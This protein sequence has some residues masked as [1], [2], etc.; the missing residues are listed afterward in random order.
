M[1]EALNHF[2]PLDYVIFL[3]YLAITVIVGLRFTKQQKDIKTYLLAGKT[4]GAAVV[5]ISVLAAFFSGISYL[6]YPSEIYSNGIGFFV[7]GLS[8]FIATPITTII[9]LP[10]FCRSGFLTAYQYLLASPPPCWTH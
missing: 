3:A 6:A 10:F 5:G 2:R 9:F 8:F 4:M 1:P 7:V